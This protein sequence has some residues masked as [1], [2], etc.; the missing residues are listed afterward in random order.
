M[1]ESTKAS[2]PRRKSVKRAVLLQCIP[3][4]GA[5]SCVA[6]GATNQALVILPVMLWWLVLVFGLGYEYLGLRRRWILAAIAG[7]AIA[8]GSCFASFAGVS[9]DFEH[10]GG[11]TGPADYHCG[12]IHGADRAA[13]ETGLVVA[14]ATLLF[15]VDVWRLAK[16]QNLDVDALER[17]EPDGHPG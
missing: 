8:F 1:T 11:G 16:Q 4:L 5:A 6:S 9:Y 14:G 13:V 7:P 3:M 15:A 10:C 17:G 12:G 2:G